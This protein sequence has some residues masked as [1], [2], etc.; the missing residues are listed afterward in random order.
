MKMWKNDGEHPPTKKEKKQKKIH[1]NS[2]PLFNVSQVKT[3]SP[4]GSQ[5]AHADFRESLSIDFDEA[6][7]FALS[8]YCIVLR[9]CDWQ[10]PRLRET[11][12]DAIDCHR[13]L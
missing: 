5:E 12:K 13:L 3:H 6:G 11:A 4:C 1:F 9:P 7:R 10:N 8:A 2:A